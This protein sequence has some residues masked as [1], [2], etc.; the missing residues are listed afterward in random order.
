MA[1]GSCN[2]ND[3]RIDKDDIVIQHVNII[4]V[5]NGDIQENMTVI[6]SDSRIQS[7]NITNNSR[8]LGPGKVVDATGK[9][10]IPGLW[11]MHAHLFDE[12]NTREVFY[13]LFIANGITGI[14]VMAADCFEPCEE[15]NMTIAQHRSLQNEIRLGNILGPRSILG[16]YYINGAL[17]GESTVLKPRTEQHGRELA[18]LL[19]DR[20]P[21]FIKI[22]SELMPEAYFGLTDEAKKLNLDFAGHVPLTM[23]SSAVSEA[24]QK[25]IEHC[26]EESLFIECSQIEEEMRVKIIEMFRKEQG[27]FNYVNVGGI[28]ELTLKQVQAFDSLKCRNIYG[29]FKRNNTWVVPTLY[30]FE[31]YYS[32][33]EDWKDK[34]TTKYIPKGEYDFF[35]NEY[36]PTMRAV[37]GPFIPEIEQK[38]RQIVADMNRYGV[39]ILAGSDVGEVGLVPGFSLHNELE[40]L[41]KAGLTP[42][43]VL[44][45]ATL[46]PA[47]YQEALDSLG[48]ITQGKI[49]DMVLLNANPLEDIR[50]TQKIEAVF[51]NG[52]YLNRRELDTLLENVETYV[53]SEN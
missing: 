16:S 50:N 33:A 28:N 6:I 1:L 31:I 5:E 32:D 7:I 26:C 20:D 11:D 14:R 15:P 17:G 45:T 39:G 49:A 40:S 44:Q 35:K 51:A 12:P 34:A 41:Q 22:Y 21:D 52:Y 29:I 18:R 10:L 9:Y 42:L 38:R 3:I 53:S 19:K 25:S 23:K 37:W 27:D 36:E 2:S 46:N 43:E 4:N 47:K 8:V 24:G 48:A 30:H 13:P